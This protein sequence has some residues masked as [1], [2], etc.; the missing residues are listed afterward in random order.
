MIG[1]QALVCTDITHEDKASRICVITLMV[2][3]NL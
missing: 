1:V 3:L 2:S